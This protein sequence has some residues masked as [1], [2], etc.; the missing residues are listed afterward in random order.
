MQEYIILKDISSEL[1]KIRNK[2]IEHSVSDGLAGSSFP[3]KSFTSYNFRLKTYKSIFFD[4]YY[5]RFIL[6]SVN[7]TENGISF[8][9]PC[10]LVVWFDNKMYDNTIDPH[11]GFISL[12]NHTDA[13]VLLSI[14]PEDITEK[15]SIVNETITE[16]WLFQLMTKY[17]MPCYEDISVLNSIRSDMFK[18]PYSINFCL[19]YSKEDLLHNFLINIKDFLHDQI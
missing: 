12:N 3:N 1:Y 6:S 8:S 11:R 14:N 16:E 19:R 9:E 10:S 4:N 7:D 13:D 17:D 15:I 5:Y 2:N 18:F